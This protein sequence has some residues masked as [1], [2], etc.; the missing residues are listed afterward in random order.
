MLP[1]PLQ[2]GGLGSDVSRGSV[3]GGNDLVSGFERATIRFGEFS[4]LSNNARAQIV[5]FEETAWLCE[6]CGAV[7]VTS[8]GFNNPVRL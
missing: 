6:N 2:I 1:R 7:Y 4:Q 5:L 8:D 3:Y